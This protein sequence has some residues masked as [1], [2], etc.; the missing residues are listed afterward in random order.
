MTTSSSIV[1]VSSFTTDAKF[2]TWGSAVSAAVVASGLTVTSD[3]GQIN[4]TT[5]TRPTTA[6]AKAGYEIY[7]FNDSLQSTAPIFLRIDYGSAA[8]TTGANQNLWLTVG[9]GSDGAG[10]ITGV[11]FV[12]LSLCQAGTTGSSNATMSVRAAY[13]TTAGA[14]FVDA[15]VAPSA[16]VCTGSFVIQR[17]CDATGAPTGQG[18]S[19][20][21]FRGSASTAQQYSVS[22]SPYAIFASRAP[23]VGVLSPAAGSSVSGGGVIELYRLW[24]TCPTPVGS[25]GSLGYWNADI[26]AA[27]TFSAAPFGSTS[28]TYVA[29]GT[30][31]GIYEQGGNTSISA[32]AIWE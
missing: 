29:L 1:D 24:V 4:W 10:N 14:A 21:W 16:G 13:S 2:R 25:V 32:A 19:V 22:F 9:T 8:S 12:T 11:Y 15:G 31:T 18:A 17:T 26:T 20:V 30:G 3:T 27:A 28:H 5:V 23:A 7:R 6:S